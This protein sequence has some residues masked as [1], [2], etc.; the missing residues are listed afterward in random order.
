MAGKSQPPRPPLAPPQPPDTSAPS[1]RGQ[2]RRTQPS[3]ALQGGDHVQED[4]IAGKEVRQAPRWGDTFPWAEGC[5][6]WG[7][8][9]REQDRNPRYNEVTDTQLC[10]ASLPVHHLSMNSVL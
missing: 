7:L 1:P 4:L 6:V 10:L 9:G 2:H 3:T 5:A 8:G